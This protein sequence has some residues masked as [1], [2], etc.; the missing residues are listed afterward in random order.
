[1][2]SRAKAI[3]LIVVCILIGFVLGV[4]V[5]RFALKREY[6]GWKSGLSEYKKELIRRLN[7][8]EE[9]QVKLDTILGWSQR[10]FKKLSGEFKP[11]FDSLRNVVRDSIRSILNQEQL[12]EFEKMIKETEKNGRR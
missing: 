12:T 9:Q 2:S 11:R 10:E 7:L 4:V 6:S 3:V 1:M 5:D 8:T